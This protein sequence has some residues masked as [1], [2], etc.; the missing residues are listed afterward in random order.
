MSN[1]ITLQNTDEI[2]SS[3][4]V[5]WPF[6]EHVLCR[7]HPWPLEGGGIDIFK[8]TPLYI[9]EVDLS[10]NVEFCRFITVRASYQIRKI[11]GCA[12]AGM[13][14]R[15]PRHWRQRKQLVSDSGMHRDTCGT[16]V[17]WCTS[18]SLTRGGGE[19]ISA[20][21]AHAQPTILRIW[22][23]AHATLPSNM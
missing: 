18:G 11:V 4:G 17:P 16:H 7:I 12:C 20:I 22:Q 5:H 14:G 3:P 21:P 1:L 15:F 8:A 19:N 10:V 2:S 13:P 6:S 9:E 23:E